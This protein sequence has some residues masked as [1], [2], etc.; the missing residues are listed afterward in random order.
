MESVMEGDDFGFKRAMA[1]GGVV[2][3]QLKG[4]FVG[5]GAGVHKQHALGKGGVD[6][7]TPQ[8]QRRFVGKDIAG[9]P[10]GFALRFERLDQRRVTVA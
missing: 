9:V 5:F 4:R 8:T 1:G 6:N 2:A 10:Q 3:R 7:F